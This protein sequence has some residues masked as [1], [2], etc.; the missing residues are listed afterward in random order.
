MLA[1]ALSHIRVLDLSRVLAGPWC[2]QNLADLGAEV[3]KIERPGVG[4]D[5]RSWGPPWMNN[6]SDQSQG[7]SS[8]FYS[9]NRGKKSVT[10]DISTPQGK[11]VIEE[12]A[13]ICD[14][15]IENYKVG[16]LK[17]YGLGYD[18]LKK[19]NPKL[20]YCSITGYGQ[21]GPDSHKPGYDY[22]FQATGGLMSVTGERDDLPG[23]GPQKVGV[24]VADILTGMYSSVAILAALNYRDRTGEGQFID[25]ALIDSA[26]A[27]GSYQ[28]VGYFANGKI[29]KRA[30]N[31]LPSLVPYQVFN[32]SDDQIIVA[33]GN[34]GQWQKFCQAIKRPDLAENERW[35]K[36]SG[37]VSG[38]DDLVPEIS[39]TLLQASTEEWL[40]HLEKVGVPCGK[41]NNYEQ[42]FKDAHV[43]H[44]Q[45]KVDMP[46]EFGKVISTVASPLRLQKTPVRYEKT[47]PRLGDS[48]HSVL[49][50]L[51]AYSEDEYQ[52]LL[53]QKII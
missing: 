9:A 30:G 5:T 10:L 18:S 33:V 47:P 48:T 21:D 46:D 8:Y 53:N 29:P 52:I 24:A 6:P 43:Q 37:R 11:K 49:T 44:R 36:V 34:D 41:I 1:G 22:V 40:E 20:I 42:V 28:I 38:R 16:D 39:K 15:L 31:A 3:I 35:K 19:I 13:A 25:M 27:L 7:D 45:L 32:T 4:D 50:Q 23:G 2:S 14:V 17:R 12:L 26:V 51:L